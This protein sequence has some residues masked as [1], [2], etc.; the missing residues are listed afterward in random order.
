MTIKSYSDNLLFERLIPIIYKGMGNGRVDMKTI[1]KEFS[2]SNSQ[3][4][5][6][7]KAATGQ[8]LSSFVMQIRI[9]EAKRLLAM[10]PRYTMYDIARECAF[11]DSAHFTHTFRKYEGVSPTAYVK[12]LCADS[13][14]LQK[15]IKTLVEKA[16]KNNKD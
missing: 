13:E 5:R 16:V 2:L 6:R 10:W 14:R 1:S 8:T 12:D 9:E 11:A 15:Y 4:N 7:V 3:L